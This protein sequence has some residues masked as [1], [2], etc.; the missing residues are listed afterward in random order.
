MDKKDPRNSKGAIIRI[1]LISGDKF[2]SREVCVVHTKQRDFEN[3]RQSGTLLSLIKQLDG[4]QYLLLA[5]L[6][7][8][9]EETL[10]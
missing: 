6:T 10:M 4:I 7:R 9:F 1:C 3:E 2:G 8:L 5:A